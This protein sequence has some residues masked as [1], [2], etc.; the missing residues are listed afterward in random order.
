MTLI[1]VDTETG[2]TNPNT[3]ALLQIS[4]VPIEKHSL[5]E[6]F[7][8]SPHSRPYYNTYIRPNPN[9]RISVESRMIHKLSD[10]FLREKGKSEA[11]VLK[12]LVDFCSSFRS[13]SGRWPTMIG[14]N[15][16]F[17][18]KFLKA[19]FDRFP[20]PSNRASNHFPYPFY[21]RTFDVSSLWKWYNLINKNSEDFE[22]MDEA[23]KLLGIG[24]VGHNAFDDCMTTLDILNRFEGK[25]HLPLG[26]ME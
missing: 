3:D 10:D 1:I 6:W 12:E 21:W 11:I 16:D 26:S 18:E 8:Y 7:P 25:F 14:W 4:A 23:V 2:G 20:N 13:K 9:L 5:G 19:A 15:I 22:G 17:D 24:K